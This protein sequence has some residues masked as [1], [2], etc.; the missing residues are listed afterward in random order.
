MNILIQVLNFVSDLS[1]LHG[2]PFHPPAHHAP[3]HCHVMIPLSPRAS[4]GPATMLEYILCGQ[5]PV[6]PIVP[7]DESPR[8]HRGSGLLNLTFDRRSL[9]QSRSRGRFG[10]GIGNPITPYLFSF[11]PSGRKELVFFFFFLI[12]TPSDPR[13]L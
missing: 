10:F 4:P 1:T 11:P 9:F 12:L 8:G 2:L 6:G 3:H 5:H 7:V 13:Y